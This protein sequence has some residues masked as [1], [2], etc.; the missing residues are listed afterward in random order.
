MDGAESREFSHRL[1][2][3]REVAGLTQE[4]LA[5][6]AGLSVKAI[7]ALERGHRRRP[8]PHTVRAIADALGLSDA[9]RA[10]L[11]GSVPGREPTSAPPPA[12]PQPVPGAPTRMIGRE[13]ELVD[14]LTLLDD[15]AARLVT[16]T[17]A[18]GVGKTR[19]ALEVAARVARSGTAVTFVPLAHLADASLVIPAIAHALGVAELGTTPALQL[20]VGRVASQPWLLVLDNLEQ[21]LD[22][23]PSLADL[24]DVAPRLA[25]LATSRAPVRIRA[26]REYPLRPLD[27]PDLARLPTVD[28]VAAVS[29][30]QLFVERARAAEPSFTLTPATSLAV[31][32]I[33][34][35]LD[36]LPLAIELVAARARALG[37]TEL[38]ARLDQMLPLLVGGARD[39]PARQQ[40]MRAAID[41]SEQ[42]LDPDARAL[43]RRLSAFAGG[44]DLGAA[45]TVASTG[46]PAPDSVLDLLAVLIE[47][48][49][50]VAEPTSDDLTRYRMLEP[51]RQ[52][53]A[54]RLEE[55]GEQPA[56]HGHHLAWCLAFARQAARELIGSAQQEWLARLE[57]EH[58]NLRAALQRA[59]ADPVHYESGLELA[60]S[61][62]RF[63]SIRGHLTEGRRWLEGSLAVA[64]Q[65]PPETRANACNAAGNLAR[66]Q[67]DLARSA[68]LHETALV[69]RRE[70]GD[71]RSIALSLNNI[72]TV[73]M[74]QGEYEQARRLYEQALA[75]FRTLDGEW[76][77]AIALHNIGIA[78]GVQGDGDRAVASL[79]E[80][81]GI[82]ERLGETASLARSL[83]SL[84][85]VHR[86]EGRLDR[87]A[88]LHDEALRI[89][90]AL[91]NPRAVGVTLKNLGLVARYRGDLDEAARLH[92]ESL[93]LRRRI[94]DERGVAVSL[95]ALA[96]VARD[97]DDAG[98]AGRLYREALDLRRRLGTKDGVADCL[99]GLTAL[100][101]PSD[102]AQAARLVGA[103][104]ALRESIGEAIAPVDRP[105]YNRIIATIRAALPRAD[106]EAAHAAG[107]ELSPADV[108]AT[109]DPLS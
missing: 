67:G 82:W 59:H 50:V 97:R 10:L 13:R 63:W 94:G 36:G 73:R 20:V 89:G 65:V 78:L 55:S 14:V 102:P 40:T 29:S 60:A 88:E 9:E 45:E 28:E 39:L 1:R 27:V 81:I 64:D 83:D 49:L 106:F 37:P 30:V 79:E 71:R 34:R 32:A 98:E 85:E 72:G 5:E 87:A 76:E 33:C 41:W 101:T 19:L 43:F 68:E 109:I 77:V 47:Q 22:A 57:R 104:D 92:T 80:A 100:A 84:G 52:F 25:I 18:G 4:E 66:D 24:L 26:E 7:G 48:S 42:L 17:G 6:R 35:R 16:L 75:G 103:S 108:T 21:V 8:Y 93:A 70:L 86:R 90:R 38:L 15:P 12:N 91:D 105:A 2:E 69:L 58:D 44:W 51:I 23:A 11:A 54:Q 95:A 3:L 74:D 61:L 53:A 107:R 46:D 62:W 56:V 99:L 96:D 31:A